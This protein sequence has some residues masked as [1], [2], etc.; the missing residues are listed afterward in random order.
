MKTKRVQFSGLH[1]RSIPNLA[2]GTFNLDKFDEYIRPRDDP[3]Q[4]FTGLVVV[5]NTH[6]Y[7]G[8]KVLPLDFLAR[9]S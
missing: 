4:P 9:V 5:E 1:A 6:N 8:G 7:C 2:D 3:H